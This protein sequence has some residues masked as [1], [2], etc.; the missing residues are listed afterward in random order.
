MKV[1]LFTSC[2]YLSVK[3][4]CSKGSKKRIPQMF[5]ISIGSMRSATGWQLKLVIHT[6]Q[7]WQ[8]TPLHN[9]ESAHWSIP[10][11]IGQTSHDGIHQHAVR[12]IV[13]A[14]MKLEHTMTNTSQTLMWRIAKK[15]DIAHLKTLL[16]SEHGK[17][18][19]QFHAQMYTIIISCICVPKINKA[20]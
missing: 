16:K 4:L 2:I 1:A 17:A 18:Y 8:I 9:A 12:L 3:N 20:R 7:S 15:V 19:L 10:T 13:S 14:R 5:A 11:Y 6:L